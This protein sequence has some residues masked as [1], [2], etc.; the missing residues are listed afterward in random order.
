MRS[1]PVR[2]ED[3]IYEIRNGV[4]PYLTPA[5]SIARELLEAAA[6][7]RLRP[8]ELRAVGQLQFLISE[9][10]GAALKELPTLVRRL[11]TTT[12]NEEEW[13]VERVRGAILWGR[14]LGVRQAT[15][16]P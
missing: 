3:L 11:A 4:W 5:A 12:A 10:L 7:L 14:T 2:R 1:L 13:S 6:L 9:E 15:G 8:R 16:L